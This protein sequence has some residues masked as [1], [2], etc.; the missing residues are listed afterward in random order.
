VSTSRL[1]LAGATLVLATGCTGGMRR[2]N[3]RLRTDNAQLQDTVAALRLKQTELEAQLQ[4]AGEL[5]PARSL[6]ALVPQVAAIAISPLSG[7]DPSPPGGPVLQIH[8][9]A[10]D[11]RGRPIQLAGPLEAQVLEPISGQS[12]RVL[13]SIRLD[14]AGAHDA[15]RGGPLG[16]TWLIDVPL[17]ADLPAEPLLIHVEHRDLRTDRVLRAST[18]APIVPP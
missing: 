5:N 14:A 12:P 17:P 15:W 1:L 7:L 4:R 3:A 8:V 18:T 11:G 6:Q 9:V 16:A 13:A 10:V 2:A